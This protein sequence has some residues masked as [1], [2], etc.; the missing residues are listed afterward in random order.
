LAIILVEKSYHLILLESFLLMV[1]VEE[2]AVLEVQ[3]VRV[4]QVLPEVLEQ[5]GLS[6][7]QE[8]QLGAEEW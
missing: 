4:E 3:V 2:V 7:A 8:V 6:V 1:V 5:L